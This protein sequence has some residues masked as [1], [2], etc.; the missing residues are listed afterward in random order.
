MTKRDKIHFFLRKF[1]SLTGL[2]VVGVFLIF[3]GMIN[4]TIAKGDDTILFNTVAI[5]L[6]FIPYII[7]IE[8]ALVSF[9]LFHAIYGLVITYNS[10][11]NVI[12]YS[13]WRNVRFLLQRYTGIL[14]FLFILFHVISLKYL[15]YDTGVHPGENNPSM[16]SIIGFWFGTWYGILIYAVGVFVSIFHFANGIWGF[17]ITWGI[18]VGKQ[19]Q[20][21]AAWICGL[22]FIVLI[23]IFT[24]II[25]NMVIKFANVSHTDLISPI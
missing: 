9:I 20:K 13:F 5:S 1:H 10:K 21:I 18:T 11:N 22:I 8:L 7:F 19:S 25:I 24:N 2:L 16:F 17:L 4:S 3:H 15:F 6:Q 23:A 12:Q 14:I